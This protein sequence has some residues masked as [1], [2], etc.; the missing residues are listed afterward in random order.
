MLKRS[1]LL[2]L[3]AVFLLGLAVSA[4][5]PAEA[6]RGGRFIG[7][8]AVGTLL[9]LGIAGAYAGPR[10]YYGGSC[11]A[12]PRRCRYVGRSCWL[13][14]WGEEGCGGGTERCWRP[15]CC[16]VGWGLSGTVRGEA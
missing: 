1:M 2:A 6:R 7:G 5:E 11:Y 10:Y 12:G 8:L 15:T 9:G 14:R 3:A 13:N 4:S 16:S